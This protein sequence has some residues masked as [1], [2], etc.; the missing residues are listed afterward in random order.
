[1]DQRNTPTAAQRALAIPEIVAEIFTYLI[2]EPEPVDGEQQAICVQELL[3]SCS[4]VNSLWCAETMRH[5]WQHPTKGKLVS[6]DERLARVHPACRQ[7]YA[8]FVQSA[9]IVSTHPADFPRQT[10]IMRDL[11]FPKLN[12]LALCIDASRERIL[13]PWPNA[14]NVEK[15][16]RQNVS[17]VY[18]GGRLSSYGLMGKTLRRRTLT[19]LPVHIKVCPSPIEILC[20]SD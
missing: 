7:F 11:T 6:L 16:F 5:L 10:A 1:M 18:P 3:C 4:G 14:P 12:S 9:K 15:L 2:I 8:S 19:N 13:L 20:F 17:R